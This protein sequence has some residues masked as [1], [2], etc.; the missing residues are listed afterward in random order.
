[1][2]VNFLFFHLTYGR[3]MERGVKKKNLTFFSLLKGLG[4]GGG[5]KVF[6]FSFDLLKAEGRGRGLIFF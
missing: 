5:V 2:E 4:K 1:V 3:G 6:F